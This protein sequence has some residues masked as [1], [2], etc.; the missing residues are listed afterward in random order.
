MSKHARFK[1]ESIEVVDVKQKIVTPQD[2]DYKA[3][4]VQ[5]YGDDDY[6]VVFTD[7]PSDENQGFS[8]RG[9][10]KDV[11]QEM[12]DNPDCLGSDASVISIITHLLSLDEVAK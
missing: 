2:S 6:A 5:K 10:F 9:S 4:I 1:L 3:I 11:V 12:I 8:F 7:D